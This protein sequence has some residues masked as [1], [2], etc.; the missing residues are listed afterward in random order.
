MVAPAEPGNQLGWRVNVA[1]SPA[2]T[3]D[4]AAF[5][6]APMTIERGL[7]ASSAHHEEILVM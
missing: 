5:D 4:Y 6:E 2:T 1:G 3:S 7:H